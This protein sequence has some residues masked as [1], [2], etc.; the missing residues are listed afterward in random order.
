MMLAEGSAEELELTLPE[1]SCVGGVPEHRGELEKGFFLFLILDLGL[2]VG[3][4]SSRE[5]SGSINIGSTLQ[6]LPEPPSNEDEQNKLLISRRDCD[7]S[8]C[9]AV[10]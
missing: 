2:S 1:S 3:H 10:R 4:D 9:R 6:A 5:G 8:V 7:F